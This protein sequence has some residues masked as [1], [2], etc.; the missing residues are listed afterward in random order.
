MGQEFRIKASECLFCFLMPA[1][2]GD[3]LCSRS[4]MNG[5]EIEPFKAKCHESSK[6]IKLVCFPH[7]ADCTY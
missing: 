2:K 6:Q 5:L 1:V 7:Q 3:F 4:I